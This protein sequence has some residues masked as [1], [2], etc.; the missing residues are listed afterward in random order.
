MENKEEFRRIQL[1]PQTRGPL[2]NW[3]VPHPVLTKDDDRASA[4]SFGMRTD[5]L[6]LNTEGLGI[7]GNTMSKRCNSLPVVAVV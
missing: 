6:F 1:Y 3:M 5:V 7:Q 4:G 2:I